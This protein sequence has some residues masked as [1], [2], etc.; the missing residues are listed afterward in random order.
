MTRKSEE[1][2]GLL[3]WR[4]QFRIAL[5][6]FYFKDA[7]HRPPILDEMM[8]DINRLIN[9]VA[10][11]YYDR[12]TSSLH[13]DELV[14]ESRLKLAE[15]LDRGILIRM[16]TRA[17]FFKFF[18][19]SLNNMARSRVQKYRFTEKR[20]G[21]KPPP[22]HQR[23]LSG[24]QE[25]PEGEVQSFE[26]TKNVELSLDDPDSNVQVADT[27]E[28]GFG[29]RAYA[30]IKEE[31]ES[32][33]SEVEIL[34]FRQMVNPNVK[35]VNLATL[36]ARRGWRGGK[37]S[38]RIRNEHLAASIGLL[39]EVF[40]YYVLSIR[41]KIMAHKQMTSHDEE[42]QVRFNASMAQLQEV[43]GLQ[44]PPDTDE[45]IVRRMLTFAA[46]DQIDRVNEQVEEMLLEVGA[47]VPLPQGD[48]ISCYGIL[49]SRN[50]PRCNRCS[51]RQGCM[52]ES[53]T[54]GME[55]IQPS[56]K[57]L[58]GRQIRVPVVLPDMEDVVDQEPSP[59]HI[60]SATALD[61]VAEHF[62]QKTQHGSIFYTFRDGDVP[63]DKQ[64]TKVLLCVDERLQQIRLCG[65]SS[66]LRKR[67]VKRRKGYYAPDDGEA[68]DVIALID[69]HAKEV[70]AL[71]NG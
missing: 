58:G 12:T 42:K 27:Y 34:I 50:H 45:I 17:E 7:R 25:D 30:E 15:L 33:L 41:K 21:V 64:G 71:L 60:P 63:R 23:Q 10:L 5:A 66:E 68:G 39:P 57:L 36:D 40:T 54:I 3:F 18:K 4:D 11:R 61:Y 69:Q 62:Y 8:P 35:A 37:L 49:Y 28:E 29:G 59:A 22:R 46:R 1:I 53:A 43:F 65:P 52:A 32:I 9:S 31:F 19:A 51:L 38:V 20:T 67:L 16:R 13:F 14:G 47:K 70:M 48:K 24:T 56:L 26:S 55:S 44:I 6:K 2:G